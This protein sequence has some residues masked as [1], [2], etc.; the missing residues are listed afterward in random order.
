[1]DERPKIVTQNVD[2]SPLV[3]RTHQHP[4]DIFW[5]AREHFELLSSQSAVPEISAKGAGEND[6]GFQ[7]FC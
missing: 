6:A 4:S 7:M 1:M 3:G 5:G 2:P